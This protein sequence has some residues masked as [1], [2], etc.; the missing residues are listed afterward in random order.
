MH[1]SGREN[2]VRFDTKVEERARRTERGKEGEDEVRKKA[3]EKERERDTRL[4][5][6]YRRFGGNKVK[7]EGSCWFLQV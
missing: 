1:A 3:R 2:Y 6:I 4:L 5:D 7:H